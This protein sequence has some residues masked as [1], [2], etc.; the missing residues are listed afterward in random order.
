[1]V[2][3]RAFSTIVCR[4]AAFPRDSRVL[5]AYLWSQL[6]IQDTVPAGCFARGMI[7]YDLKNFSMVSCVLA[8]IGCARAQFM[9][10]FGCLLRVA[11]RAAA[12]C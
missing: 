4:P 7:E 10:I 1:M 8:L 12:G 2:L 5:P 3:R 11:V 6:V 9:K